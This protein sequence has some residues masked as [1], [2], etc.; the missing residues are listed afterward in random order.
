MIDKEGSS[1]IYRS[2]IV[3]SL[4]FGVGSVD[5]QFA[6]ARGCGEYCEAK[7]VLKICNDKVKRWNL[8]G[9][10]REAE[11][12]KRKTQ[13]MNSESASEKAGDTKA[14]TD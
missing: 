13:L 11:F 5:Y 3:A 6:F 10:Q 4:A 9:Q 12:N 14:G 2:I 8:E 7:K 1:W